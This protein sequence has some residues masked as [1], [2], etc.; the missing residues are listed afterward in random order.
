MNTHPIQWLAP[1]PLW[2][3]FGAAPAAAAVADDQKRPAILRFASDDFMERMLATL[4]RDPS[5]IDRLVARPESW[6]S[7]MRES[8]DLIERTPVPLVA[9]GA[10]RGVFAR[11]PKAPVAATTSEADDRSAQGPV[12]KLPL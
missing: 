4:A 12:R 5:R 1:Q 8:P 10:K 7:P 9:K 3:R 2:G 6:R 11:L